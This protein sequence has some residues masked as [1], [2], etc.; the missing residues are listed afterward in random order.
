MI[1]SV[2]IK[3]PLTFEEKAQLNR[4]IGQDINTHLFI[5]LN[6]V[7]SSEEDNN[8]FYIKTCHVGDIID[9]VGNVHG[10]IMNLS[11]RV[12]NLE[13]R[14]LSKKHLVNNLNLLRDIQI[15]KKNK[16]SYNISQ[17]I[18]DK[19]FYEANL[20]YCV[21]YNLV[22]NSFKHGNIKEVNISVEQNNWKNMNPCLIPKGSKK[23]NNFIGFHV[24]DNGKGF[25]KDK[26]FREY[27]TKVPEE[28]GRGFGLY[29]TGLVSKV[30]RAPVEI[31][32]KPGDTIVSFYQPIYSKD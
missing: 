3:N 23:Y 31:K 21:L 10:T 5:A 19:F 26:D 28:G 16:V 22:K 30:L 24:Q 11:S 1:E 25:P 27:F 29:F 13:E 20:I 14:L 2:K 9:H 7:Y 4:L 18:P 15:N 32:S 8:I 12:F 17:N 6:A